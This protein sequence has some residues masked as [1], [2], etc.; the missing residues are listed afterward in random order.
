MKILHVGTG[1]LRIPPDR[2][3]AVELYIYNLSRGLAASGHEVTVL[4]IKE[5]PG[6]PD[7]EDLDGIKRLCIYRKRF[8]FHSRHPRL[9]YLGELL[10][11]LVFA[12]KVSLYLRQHDYDVIHLHRLFSSSAIVFLNR[13]LRT[14]M[15]YTAHSSI[16]MKENPGWLDRLAMALD[17]YTM[18]RVSRVL[19]Q[20]ELLKGQFVS[21]CK[22]SPAKIA[23][24]PSGVDTAYYRPEG[25]PA[26]AIKHRYGLEGR[27]TVLCVGHIIPRKGLEYLV[28]AAALL[29]QEPSHRETLF[30]LVG[31]MGQPGFDKLGSANYP[32]RIIE[33]IK[34]EGLGQRVRLTGA[35]SQDDLLG[36]FCACDI[37]VLPSLSESSPAVTLQAMSCAKPVIATRVGGLPDQIKDGWNGFLV[38]PADERAL[39][40]KIACLLDHPAERRRMGNNG[41]QFA[42][43]EFDWKRV[44]QKA[45]VAYGFECGA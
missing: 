22:I 9:N 23:V 45:L 40:E 31:P 30:L 21:A 2:Y 18:R 13:R 43:Q 4:D 14:K 29:A 10:D 24:I 8:D 3:G 6:E 7:L 17:K 42:E 38:E 33:I 36:L 5:S 25:A 28:K 41:R 35:V 15:V 26:H 39:A 1:S 37:F 19:A 12:F 16:W 32:A 11:V 34:R 20:A 27:A 44:S